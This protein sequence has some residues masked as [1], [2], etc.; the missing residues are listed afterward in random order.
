MKQ[1]T[2]IA[3][4]RAF[5]TLGRWAKRE[6]S[7]RF[8]LLKTLTFAERFAGGYQ[9]KRVLELGSSLGLHLVAAKE[10]GAVQAVGA[11]KFIFPEEGEND[12]LLC[13]EELDGLRRIWKEKGIEV[14]RH[15]LADPL[16]FPDGSFDLVVCNAVVEH[17]HT[18]HAHVFKEVF[19]V[20]SH[21]GF[22]VCTTPNLA[23]ILKRLRFLVGRSP[24]WDL[25][26]YVTQ[27]KR[28]TGHV[29]EFTVPECRAMLS[30]SGFVPV[31]VVARP[32]YFRWRWFL[33]P[34]KIHHAVLFVFAWLSSRWGDLIYAAGRKP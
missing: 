1:I 32:G 9:G 17:L 19:R 25:R 30:W 8:R 14:V 18:I 3:L 26:D 24:L 12:F 10:L 6:G 34:K 13:Q 29:R 27:G 7:E 11:E 20:L 33:M 16:P 15:D 4:D 5:Y 22:F 31:K 23:S 21:G 2:E 28:F